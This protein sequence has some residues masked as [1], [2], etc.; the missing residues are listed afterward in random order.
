MIK[1]AKVVHGSLLMAMMAAQ[2]RLWLC[3]A[4]ATRS[5]HHRMGAVV[6]LRSVL[7]TAAPSL[8]ASLRQVTY[9]LG[10][11]WGSLLSVC[12]PRWRSTMR[13]QAMVTRR[14]MPMTSRVVEALV[15]IVLRVPF[16][17]AQA[18]QRTRRA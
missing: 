4:L 18:A 13:L 5:V 15:M 16:P 12:S 10:A 9:S 1:F 14:A 3:D 11:C 7:R 17:G 6:L 2:V 8:W